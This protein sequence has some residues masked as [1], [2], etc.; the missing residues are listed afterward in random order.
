MRARRLS[1]FALVGLLVAACGTQDPGVTATRSRVIQASPET[2]VDTG[3]DTVPDATDAPADTGAGDT[4]GDTGIAVPTFDTTPVD[5]GGEPIDQDV[6]DFG[7]SKT[8]R[9][10]DDYLVT[11]LADIEAFW[12]QQYPET[13]GSQWTP[14][15]GGIFAAYQSREEPIPGCGTRETTFDDVA[16]NAFYCR[17]GDFMVYD[18]ELL[19]PDLVENLGETSVGVVLA[20]EFGHAIQFRNDDFDEPTI[21]KE[22]Q[23]DCF[24]GSWAAHVARG[25]TDGLVFGDE[26][27]KQGLVAMIQVRDPVETSGS[28]DPNAHGTGFDRVGAFQDG[29]VGGP[30]RCASF[31]T[32]G[33][34]AQ[35]IRIPFDPFD[36]NSGNLPLVDPTG[37]TNDFVSLIPDDLT[38]FWTKALAE[39]AVTFT[40]PT[41]EL[42]PQDG[43]YPECEGVSDERYPRN[44]F[45]CEATNIVLMDQDLAEELIA[46]P[47]FGDLSVGYLVGTA[48]SEAVQ[49]AMGSSLTG[50]ERVLANDCFTGAWTADDIPIQNPDDPNG[51]AIAAGGGEL[52]LSAGDL[53]EA[54]ITAIQLS[55]D[56]ADDDSRG[57][58]FEKVDA[59]RSG[60]FNGVATCRALIG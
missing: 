6:I 9:G 45:Y 43:P 20:H 1:A 42:Y 54:V 51:P 22:Q 4:T 59:F 7:G 35:L 8:T 23:A 19:L 24:A 29:F 5:T 25:E 28:N 15:E 17:I 50:E 34:E 58:A 40:P 12:A 26:E 18:D 48:V 52:F 47:L 44:V 57:T 30:E 11:A 56:D 49:I 16:G 21:L 37:G 39:E 41:L 10:Y 31:F 55:D 53:D 14:L 32:E 27:I 38:R 2:S 36:V 3:P 60:V 13:Y 33:R 46:D